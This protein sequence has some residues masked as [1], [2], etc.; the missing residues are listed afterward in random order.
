MTDL[1]EHG[2]RRY[3]L[4]RL[5]DIPFDARDREHPA[6]RTVRHRKPVRWARRGVP[7][8]QGR[9]GSCTGNALAGWLNTISGYRGTQKT[10]T[11]A[12]AYYSWGTHC[13]AI[14]GVY[15]PDDTGSTGPAVA[16]AARNHGVIAGWTHAFG[17]DHLLDSLQLGPVMVGSIW[18]AGMFE[19]DMQGLVTPS[20]RVVGGHEY[21]A[22]EYVPDHGLIGFQQSWGAWGVDGRFYMREVDVAALL[23]DHGDATVPRLA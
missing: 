11:D 3:P 15:P 18:L 7:L 12:V 5:N 17:I 20:G 8:D 9:V 2:G 16:R 23:R 1:V 14:R 6:A 21:V 22:D 19:V 13:D 4:G 10:E